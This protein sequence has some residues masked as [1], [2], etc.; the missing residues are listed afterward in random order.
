MAAMF[1]GGEG[2]DGGAVWERAKEKE[3]RA[4]DRVEKHQK[5]TQWRRGESVNKGQEGGRRF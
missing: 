1:G 4:S 5:Q 3:V 2:E